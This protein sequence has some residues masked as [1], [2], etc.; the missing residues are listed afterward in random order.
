M[1]QG[2]RNTRF[3]QTMAPKIPHDFIFKL[4][5]NQGNWVDD[6]DQIQSLLRESFQDRFSFDV[7]QQRSI[8]LDFLS[9]FISDADVDSLTASLIHS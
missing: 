9:P 4:K 7:A 1:S 5:D 3:F 2:D 8:N 6:Q